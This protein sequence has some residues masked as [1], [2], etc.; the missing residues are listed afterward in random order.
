MR[1]LYPLPFCCKTYYFD[2]GSNGS[3]TLSVIKIRDNRGQYLEAFIS[4]Y[5][6]G[7]CLGFSLLTFIDDLL[8]R[9][10]R[11]PNQRYKSKALESYQED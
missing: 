9:Q 8:M 11:V 6:A 10:N 4:F 3:T 7:F 2:R 1:G 5:C